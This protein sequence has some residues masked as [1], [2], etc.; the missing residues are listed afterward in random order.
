MAPPGKK[1]E[2]GRSGKSFPFLCYLYF[3]TF[4][5]IPN[6]IFFRFT[7]CVCVCARARACVCVCVYVCVCAFLSVSVRVRVH[8]LCKTRTY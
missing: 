3:D 8:I 1:Q 2:E 7:S 5:V 6:C 4:H